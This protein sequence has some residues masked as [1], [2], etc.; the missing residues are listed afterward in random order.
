MAAEA[1]DDPA[2]EGFAWYRVRGPDGR[3]HAIQQVPD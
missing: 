1:F 2:Y 3:I